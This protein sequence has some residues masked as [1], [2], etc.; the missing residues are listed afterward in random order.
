MRRTPS[1]PIEDHPIPSEI[2]RPPSPHVADYDEDFSEPSPSIKLVDVEPETISEHPRSFYTT[3]NP[4]IPVSVLDR[5]MKNNLLF[6]LLERNPLLILQQN[7][8]RNLLS[9]KKNTKNFLL[10][11]RS[12]TIH[13][14]IISDVEDETLSEKKSE[15]ISANLPLT[16]IDSVN[17]IEQSKHD[18]SSTSG[19]EMSDEDNQKQ[20]TSQ[21]DDFE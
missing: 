1:P 10:P 18:A 8:R 3:S 14:K 4:Q 11:H 12:M 15:L 5:V 20:S 2:I 6:L 9:K 17:D 21:K 13:R 7:P 16:L 19:E